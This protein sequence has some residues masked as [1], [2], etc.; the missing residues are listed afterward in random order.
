VTDDI[1]MP[2]EDCGRPIRLVRRPIRRPRP[3][4]DLF[5][6]VVVD[7]ERINEETAP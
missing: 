1:V 5:V 2:C 7:D 4:R 6:Y 3:G